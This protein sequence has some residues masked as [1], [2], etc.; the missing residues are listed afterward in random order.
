MG[1]WKKLG[2][3]WETARA[4]AP[5]LPIS[6]K[7]KRVIQKSGEVEDDV[8]AIVDDVKRKPQSPPTKPAA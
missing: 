5:V 8:K 3:I 1:F 6:D 7:A 2:G 4:I